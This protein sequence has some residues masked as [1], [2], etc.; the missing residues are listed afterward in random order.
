MPRV[1]RLPC[2]RCC[3]ALRCLIVAFTHYHVMPPLLLLIRRHADAAIFIIY[4]T[5]DAARCPPLAAFDAAFVARM[6][7]AMMFDVT[8]RVYTRH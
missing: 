4:A 3:L 1:F 5:D 7:A 6:L 2:F 8:P